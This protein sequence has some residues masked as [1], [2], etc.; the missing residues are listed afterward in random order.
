MMF[1]I[2][3]DVI[4]GYLSEDRGMLTCCVTGSHI[5]DHEPVNCPE[6]VFWVVRRGGFCFNGG[7]GGG[8][9]WRLGLWGGAGAWGPG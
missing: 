4:S 8:G 5:V 7:G 1:F 3:I 2:A 9:G 6:G